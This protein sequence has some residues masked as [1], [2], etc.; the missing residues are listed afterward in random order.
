MNDDPSSLPS[1]DR[2][3]ALRAIAPFD[4]VRESELALLSRV[5]VTRSFAPGATI[6]RGAEPLAH[7]LVVTGGDARDPAGNPVGPIVG[8]GSLL[9]DESMPP[10]IADR[11]LGAEILFIN[12]PTFFTLVRE[13]PELLRGFLEIGPTGRRLERFE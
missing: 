8:L 5:L 3:L 2:P 1:T 7:L 9:A 10:L 13:C 6:H 4:R 12:R 11:D